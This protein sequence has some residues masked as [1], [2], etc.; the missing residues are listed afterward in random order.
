ME[1][2]EP[3]AGTSTFKQTN[4]QQKKVEPC[5]RCNQTGNE[6]LPP[7]WLGKCG[8][9]GIMSG[10]L[11]RCKERYILAYAVGADPGGLRF[12]N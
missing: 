12:E 5:T 2:K 3:E 4:R 11:I 7:M 1:Y 10:C 8:D 6:E 9:R